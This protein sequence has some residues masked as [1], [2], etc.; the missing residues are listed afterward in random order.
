[1]LTFNPSTINSDVSSLTFNI[2]PIYHDY[3]SKSYNFN[4]YSPQISG[5]LNS[6]GILNILDVVILVGVILDESETNFAS[7][8][9]G[10]GITNILDIVTLINL[11]LS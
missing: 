4:I 3:D 10:D 2:Q 7:D 8:V 1:M 11:I 6:D 5:D 9:N